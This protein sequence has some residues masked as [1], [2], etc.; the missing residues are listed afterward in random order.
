MTEWF[1]MASWSPY[2]VGAGIGVLI[3]TTFLLSDR[4]LC[5]FD[6]SYEEQEIP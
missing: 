6:G 4:P 1:M 3:W 2:I 5:I